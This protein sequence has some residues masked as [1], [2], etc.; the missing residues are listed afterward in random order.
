MTVLQQKTEEEPL[1]S[2]FYDFMPD[3]VFLRNRVS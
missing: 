1:V 3:P 2:D